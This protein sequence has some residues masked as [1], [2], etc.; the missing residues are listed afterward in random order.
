[1]TE[2]G[3]KAYPVTISA[4][5]FTDFGLIFNAFYKCADWYDDDFYEVYESWGLLPRRPRIENLMRAR[6]LVNEIRRNIPVSGT[7]GNPIDVDDDE[8][9][10]FRMVYDENPQADLE[11]NT[12]PLVREDEDVYEPLVR[13]NAP[14]RRRLDVLSYIPPVESVSRQVHFD[15]ESVLNKRARV[16]LQDIPSNQLAYEP[17]VEWSEALTTPAPFEVGTVAPRLPRRKGQRNPLR[18]NLY[19]PLEWPEEM[20]VTESPAMRLPKRKG[21]IYDLRRLFED[22]EEQPTKYHRLDEL[23]EIEDGRA[24]MEAYHQMMDER[25]EDEYLRQHNEDLAALRQMSEE[26]LITPYRFGRMNASR[27]DPPED[28]HDWDIADEPSTALVVVPNS[29][30]VDHYQPVPQ[31]D[32]YGID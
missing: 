28:I 27:N 31:P 29:D 17:N 19:M 26:G 9:D 2:E 23:Q 21:R 6:E 1:M 7:R 10:L 18:T 25:R 20:Q 30:V 24:E 5:N 4:G 15:D 11:P 16:Q 13:K 14:D 22:E 32:P 12:F 3:L 8:E